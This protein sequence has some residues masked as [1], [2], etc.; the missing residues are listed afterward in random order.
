MGFVRIESPFVGVTPAPGWTS[1][2]P[3]GPSGPCGPKGQGNV[4][5]SSGATAERHDSTQRGRVRKGRRETRSVVGSVDRSRGVTTADDELTT[6]DAMLTAGS[7]APAVVLPNHNGESVDLAARSVVEMC[8]L[9]LSPRPTRPAAP[10]RRAGC[11]TSRRQLGD[12]VVLGISPDKVPALAK[13]RD[14]VRR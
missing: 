1:T 8:C 11:A 4:E 10:S 13:F 5:I 3:S 6:L 9:L 2:F 12:T 14:Q 7:P